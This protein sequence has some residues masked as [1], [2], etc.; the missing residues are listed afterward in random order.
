[1]TQSDEPGPVWRWPFDWATSKRFW[2]NVAS[3]VVA[4]LIVGAGGLVVV[5]F[6]G[7]LATESSYVS[8]AR[9]ATTALAAIL[10]VGAAA[11]AAR[12]YAGYTVRWQGWRGY[13]DEKIK[14]LNRFSVILIILAVLVI[15]VWLA[16]WSDDIAHW[17]WKIRRK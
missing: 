13:S 14:R 15:V 6:S 17:L 11:V 12:S 4:G 7:V 2:E 1:V 16:G 8:V 9:V 3:N 5:V 10:G